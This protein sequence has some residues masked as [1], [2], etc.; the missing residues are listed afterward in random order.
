MKVRYVLSCKTVVYQFR[1][2]NNNLKKNSNLVC[3]VLFVL[4]FGKVNGLINVLIIDFFLKICLKP[5]LSVFMT[6][7]NDGWD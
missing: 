4:L 1:K 5:V 2:E 7:S 6:P 3:F